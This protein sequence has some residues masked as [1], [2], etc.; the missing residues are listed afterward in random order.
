MA[1]VYWSIDA[2]RDLQDIATFI[3]IDSPR[4]ARVFVDHLREAAE[5]LREFP[6][7]GRSVP[8]LDDPEMRELIIRG[9]RI[10]YRLRG[11]VVGI[12]AVIHSA[13]DVSR[14]AEREPGG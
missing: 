13:R 3:A 8:E 6:A 5:R 14:L 9:Y 12:T 4:Q 10:I 1:Q 7:R 2:R 11:S